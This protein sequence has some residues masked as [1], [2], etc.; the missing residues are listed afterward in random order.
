[1]NKDQKILYK[2]LRSLPDEEALLWIEKEFP[3][4]D[5]QK[6]GEALNLIPHRSWKKKSQER[7]A[8]IYL[9]FVFP[10]GISRALDVFGSFMSIEKLTDILW[11]LFQ[12]DI[13]KLDLINYHLCHFSK[14]LTNSKKRESVSRLKNRIQEKLN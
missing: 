10:A 1:M 2:K 13:E 9:P 5:G 3:A 8:R 7:L 6:V 4:L 12:D 11:D 14:Q